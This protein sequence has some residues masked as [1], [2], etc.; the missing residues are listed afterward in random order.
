MSPSQNV[1]TDWPSATSDSV[2]WS[3]SVP[4]RTAARMPMGIPISTTMPIAVPASWTVMARRSRTSR[5]AGSP[6]NSETPKSPWTSRP[7]YRTYC[8][9]IGR[10]SP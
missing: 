6:W 5:S 4:R 1:A 3:M 9:R 8:S 7:T 2:T 10:S